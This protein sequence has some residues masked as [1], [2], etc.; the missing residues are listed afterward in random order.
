MKKK[1]MC[2]FGTRSESI[3][4]APV[5]QALKTSLYLT[6]LVV[7]TGY[8]REILD[9]MIDCLKIEVDLDLNLNRPRLSLADHT[10]LMISGLEEAFN[11]LSPDLL[12]VQGDTLM[13]MTAALVA[14]YHK[15]PVAHIE[16]GLRTADRYNPFAEEMYRR[17]ASQLSTLHFAPTKQAVENLRRESIEKHVY[18]TGNTVIDS[19]TAALEKVETSRIDKEKLFGAADF[20]KY[21]V[22][23][24]SVHRREN[25]GAMGEIAAALIQIVD[26]FPDTQILYPMHKNPVIYDLIEAKIKNHPRIVLIEPV[27]YVS[28]VRA[29]QNCFFILTDSG[30]IQEEA[31][32]LGKPVLV[33]RAN[34][35]RLEGTESGALQIVGTARDVIFQAARNLLTASSAYARRAK[36][37]TPFGE[38]NASR[39]IVDIIELYLREP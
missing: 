10:A 35:E 18:L 39:Q 13:V 27:D 15:V 11:K 14:H 9:Q 3:K 8:H 25:R 34:T 16:A 21:R 6:P 12:V 19:L 1:V 32:M 20:T 29:M 28:F 36:S 23:L 38:G 37:I 31:P 33:L 17:L 22:L 26:Q 30:G 5:I 2:V 7:I 4:L 24:A